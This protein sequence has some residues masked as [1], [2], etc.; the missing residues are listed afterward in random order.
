MSTTDEYAQGLR[1]NYSIGACTVTLSRTVISAAPP[2]TLA[3]RGGGCIES[4]TAH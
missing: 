3:K 2:G 4:G 1:E